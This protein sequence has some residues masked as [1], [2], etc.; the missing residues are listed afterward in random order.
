MNRITRR[1]VLG[2]PAA[3]AALPAPGLAQPAAA[4]TLRFVPHANLTSLDP[5]WT[6]AWITRNHAY[7]VYD[8][9][10]SLDANLKPKPQMAAGHTVENDGKLWTITLRDGLRFHDNEPVRAQDAGASLRRWGRRDPFGQTLMEQVDEIRA[11]DDKRLQIVLKR[12]FPLLLDA[13]G[14]V[15]AC[16]VMPE[17]FA[18]TDAFTQITEVVGSGPWR[19]LRPE[20]VPGSLA[21]YARF[22]GYVPR[23]EPAEMTAGGKRA[24]FDRIEWRIMPDPATAAAA[25]QSGEI[26]MWENPAFDLLPV[27]RRHRAV[28]VEQIEPFGLVSCLRPN[29]TQ[30][31]FNNPA[32]RRAVWPALS[33]ADVMTAVAGA[34]RSGWFDRMGYF[35][36]GTPL[37]S[38]A[39]L[40]AITAPR[41]LDAARRAVE[42]SGYRGEKVVFMHT[43]DISVLDAMS[44]V[45]ADLFRKLGLNLEH[46]TTDW[47]TVVQRRANRNPVEQGGWSAFCTNIS[48]A[49]TLNPAINA[50]LRT[51]GA[52]AWFGWP[53]SARIE[54]GRTAWFDA[55]DLE[56]QQRITTDLQRHAFEDVPYYPL[57]QYRQP[58]AFRR[59]M[60]GHLRAPVPLLWNITK[61][62]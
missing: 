42:A 54:A 6:T 33:Q 19:F 23:D 39:G 59:G 2:A 22:E 44:H 11:A 17:R 7:L 38:D 52:D 51:N 46:I 45:V 21:A 55:P 41:S 15:A 49:D 35:T 8:T 47:G 13:I 48:G 36:P 56:T 28:Q 57:G 43:T 4:R 25:L 9:L 31:P 61:P 14:K 18:A 30:P 27:L 20:W 16:F 50:L 10:Y 24:H 34:D 1:A 29:H 62:G 12:P 60:A 3:L 58:V 37:A 26:D 5:V 53:T 40:E 32:L